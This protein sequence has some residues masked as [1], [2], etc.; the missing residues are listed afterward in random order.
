MDS[1]RVSEV[2]VADDGAATPSRPASIAPEP[3]QYG[4]HSQLLL[5]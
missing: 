5:L 1:R 4:S 2:L 3:G